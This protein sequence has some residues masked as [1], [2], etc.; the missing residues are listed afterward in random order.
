[1][2]ICYL[3]TN[4]NSKTMTFSKQ[5]HEADQTDY[6]LIMHWFYYDNL[7]PSNLFN[8]K[9]K[10]FSKQTHEADQPDYA[11]IIYWFYYNNLFHSNFFQ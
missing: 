7:L 4:F 10:T 9:T 8:I 2:I 11:L 1:M 6:A 5:A 3:V